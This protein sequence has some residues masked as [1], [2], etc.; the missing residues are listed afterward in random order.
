VTMSTAGVNLRIP[1]VAR[2]LGI[3]GPDVYRLIEQGE[4]KAG[5]GA[6]G[7][8]YVPGT[9]LADYQQSHANTPS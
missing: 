1:E 7:F 5:K 6:D 2:Q 9:A 8:V 3:D 4:L